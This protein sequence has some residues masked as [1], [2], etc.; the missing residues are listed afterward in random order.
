M[1]DITEIERNDY[2]QPLLSNFPAVD[3]I[4]LMTRRVFDPSGP[5]EQVGVGFQAT[6]S[7][8]KRKGVA[9]DELVRVRNNLR[10]LTNIPTLPLL[11]VF[12]TVVGGINSRQRLGK[13]TEPGDEDFEQ[14][15]IRGISFEATRGM[16]NIPE[17]AEE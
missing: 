1:S 7:K 4:A 9:R 2:Y 12:V 17:V 6:V 5:D 3:A 15:V 16:K 14:F 10:V 8:N 13:T 11:L